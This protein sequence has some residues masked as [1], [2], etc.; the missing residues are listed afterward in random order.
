[1]SIT[2]D[3]PDW[4]EY[5]VRFIRLLPAWVPDPAFVVEEES[6]ADHGRM[7]FDWWAPDSSH[8]LSVCIEQSGKMYWAMLYGDER[9]KGKSVFRGAIPDGV[10]TLLRRLYQPRAA[11]T[12]EAG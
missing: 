8:T 1:M 11:D 4:C 5:G 2:T 7:D 9:A 12:P 10:L 6:G 3:L